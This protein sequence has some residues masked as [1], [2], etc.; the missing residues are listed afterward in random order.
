METK[1]KRQCDEATLRRLAE[2]RLK[3][4]EVRKKKAELKRAE[5]DEKKKA[6]DAKYEEKVLKKQPEKPQ[7]AVIEETE[8]EPYQRLAEAESVADSEDY[9]VELVPPR[10]KPA[11]RAKTAPMV[12][13]PPV[14]EPNYKQEYYKMKLSSLQQ[15]QHQQQQYQQ[16]AQAPPYQH[17]TDIARQS[18]KQKVDRHVLEKAYKDLFSC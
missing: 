4:N 12:L 11:P 13:P 10:A 1:P 8:K 5:K 3:A 15:H 14:S 16:Y 2:M 18:I 17:L 9:Q 7:E 6:F